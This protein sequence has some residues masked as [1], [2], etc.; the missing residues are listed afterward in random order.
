MRLLMRS[1][2]ILAMSPLSILFAPIVFSFCLYGRTDHNARPL[3]AATHIEFYPHIASTP[4][5]KGSQFPTWFRSP[6][7]IRTWAKKLPW[8]TSLAAFKY[9]R[10]AFY[11]VTFD[12]YSGRL[13]YNTLFYV[14]NRGRWFLIAYSYGMEAKSTIDHLFTIRTKKSKVIFLVGKREVGSVRFDHFEQ[15]SA[16][17]TQS[18]RTP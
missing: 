6:L 13:S 3:E 16:A 10:N 11:A 9:Q 1:K 4:L 5:F 17:V 2:C 14:Y 12:P 18:R 7:G 8:A 15:A